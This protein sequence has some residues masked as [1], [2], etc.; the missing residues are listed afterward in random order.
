MD[1]HRSG[2]SFPIV[3]QGEADFVLGFELLEAARAL[4][5]LKED[6]TV[7]AQSS[8]DALQKKSNVPFHQRRNPARKSHRK[9]RGMGFIALNP[10]FK[11]KTEVCPAGRG[12]RRDGLHSGPN[13]FFQNRR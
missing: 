1:A 9:R 7:K 3:A 12:I 4:P 5:Y 11:T 2:H 13:P 10:L 8:K 6:G